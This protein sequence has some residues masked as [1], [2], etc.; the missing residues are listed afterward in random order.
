MNSCQLIKTKEYI[1][2]VRM[3]SVLSFKKYLLFFMSISV[4]LSVFM[5][6]L[7]RPENGIEFLELELPMVRSHYVDV[8]H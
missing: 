3:I 4:Y 8:R 5:H 1:R 7:Q 2:S 6:M